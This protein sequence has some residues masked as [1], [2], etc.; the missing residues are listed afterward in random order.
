MTLAYPLLP[1]PPLFRLPLCQSCP[2]LSLLSSKAKAPL[3]RRR[4][5][6]SVPAD[7]DAKTASLNEAL[8]TLADVFPNVECDEFRRLLATFSEESRV[9]IITEMLLK[10][11]K[12]GGVPQRRVGAAGQ[13]EPWELFRTEEYKEVTRGLL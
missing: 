5:S 7:T 4:S 3:L 6:A 8:A 9:H 1:I 11:S 12:D 2:M 13:L 10:R